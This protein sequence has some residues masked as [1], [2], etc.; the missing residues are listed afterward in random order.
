MRRAKIHIAEAPAKNDYDRDAMALAIS[1]VDISFSVEPLISWVK[2]NKTVMAEIYLRL[3][4]AAIYHNCGKDEDAIH[5][6]DKAIVLAL[7][8][9]VSE[10]EAIFAAAESAISALQSAV[11]ALQQANASNEALQ[12]E[13]NALKGEIGKEDKASGW[14]TATTVIA[15]VGLVCNAGLIIA[16]IIFER[17]HNVI[18]PAL[19][20]GYDK[21]ASKFKK[22]KEQK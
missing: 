20:N 7:P 19:K 18:L 13:I 22:S 21:V 9:K 4:C 11:A 16:V 12:A 8:G 10:A 3:T 15:I 2:A 14:Q 17:K 6:I 1:A 5:H